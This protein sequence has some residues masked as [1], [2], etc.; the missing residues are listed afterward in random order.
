MLNMMTSSNGNIIRVTGPLCG[1]FTGAGEFPSQRPVTRSFDV[2]FDRRLN[3]QLSKQPWGWWF[4][5][6]SWSLWH[7]C[8]ENTFQ[9]FLKSFSM[10]KFEAKITQWY[11]RLCW[12]PRVALM[13]TLSPLVKPRVAIT[14]ACGVTNGDNDDIMTTVGFRCI[15]THINVISPEFQWGNYP[16]SAG[17]KYMQPQGSDDLPSRCM[18]L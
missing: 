7:Q 13:P 4:E 11:Y 3:K 17:S 8:N 16:E 1:E 2:F 9:F 14:I 18:C 15:S 6:P 12:K 5:T 10:Q